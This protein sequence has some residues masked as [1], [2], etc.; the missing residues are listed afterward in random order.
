MEAATQGLDHAIDKANGVDVDIRSSGGEWD[1]IVPL[2]DAVAVREYDDEFGC[3]D[4]SDVVALI[5]KNL[6]VVTDEVSSGMHLEIRAE[7]MRIRREVEKGS[8]EGSVGV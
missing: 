4:L 3:G 6:P 8:S 1:M 2:R 5:E 7:V